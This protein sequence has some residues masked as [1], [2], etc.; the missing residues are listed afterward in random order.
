[1][2]HLQARRPGRTGR[3]AHP[4]PERIDGTTQT[5]AAFEQSAAE[6]RHAR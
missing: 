5:F 3:G 6:G 4:H 2:T 1:M